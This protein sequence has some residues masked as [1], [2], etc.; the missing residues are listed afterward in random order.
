MNLRTLRNLRIFT[1]RHR[2]RAIPPAAALMLLAACA[3]GGDSHGGSGASGAPVTPRVDAVFADIRADTPG[4]AVGVYRNGDLLLA[5][6][7]GLANVE[8]ARPMTAQTTFNLGS[9]AKAFTALAVLTLEE[10]RKLTLDDDVRKYVPGLPDYGPPI[11][12]RDLLQHTSGLRDY[13]TLELLGGRQTPSMP[14]FVALMARQQRPNFTPGTKHE[15]SHSDFVIAG[16]IVERI[17]REPFGAY[18]ERDVL[19]PLGMTG[20]R[21]HDERGARVPARAYGYEKTDGGFGVLFPDSTVTGGSNLYTSADDLRHWD[22]A[23]HDAAIGKRPL[24]AKM[25]T[26]PALPSGEPIPYAFGIRQGR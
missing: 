26:R 24:V 25:L 12:I 7:Y 8:D 9:G 22:R 1:P 19:G 20:S 10:Q 11:R 5:K 17:V 16:L 14:E 23:L 4:C 3:A 21:V 18:L 2:R 15:Y 13:G 6:G